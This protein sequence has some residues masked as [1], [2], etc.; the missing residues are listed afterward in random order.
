MEY[1]GKYHG[2]L[3]DNMIEKKKDRKRKQIQYRKGLF[4][5]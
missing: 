4:L 2:Q 1:T 3:N 5:I